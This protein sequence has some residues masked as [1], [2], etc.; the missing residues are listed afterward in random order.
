[1][2]AAQRVSDVAAVAAG[3]P[4]ERHATPELRAAHARYEIACRAAGIIPAIPIWSVRD[5]P[6]S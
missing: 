2:E 4:P 5:R 1:V 3:V 6:A